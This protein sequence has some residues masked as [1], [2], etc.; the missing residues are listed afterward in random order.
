MRI[1]KGHYGVHMEPRTA[2]L[3]CHELRYEDFLSVKG[4]LDSM[5]DYQ[6]MAPEQLTDDNLLSI[7]WNKAPYRL[8]KEVG[9]IKDW[10]LQELF[11]QLLR[12][13]AR[14][15]ECDCCSKSKVTK[16]TPRNTA[17]VTEEDEVP[18]KKSTTPR[19]QNHCGSTEMQLKSVK[20]FKC[21]QK[22]HMAKDCPQT[23]DATRVITHE[24]ETI[25]EEESW[26][27]VR[28]LTTEEECKQNAVSNTGPTYKVNVV[29]E[30][31]HSR[32]LVDNGS[33]ISLVHTEMLPKLKE[34]N[35]WSM[36][37]CKS[38][39]CK[40]RSQ[41]QGA[42]G[43]E[44]GAKR[45]V[46]LSVTLEATGK[47]LHIPCYVVDSTR[48]LWQGAVKNCGLVLGTNAIVGFG[49]QLVHANATA[50]QPVNGNADLVDSATEKVARLVLCGVTR[51]GPRMTKRVKAKVVQTDEADVSDLEGGARVI[52]PNESVLVNVGCD[53]VEELWDVE[54]NVT[55]ELNNWG[56]EP[57]T[58]D[59]GQIGQIELVMVVGGDDTV[60][61]D[62]EQN[63]SFRVCQVEGLEER[64]EELRNRLQIAG[65]R[66][67]VDCRGINKDTIPDKYPI[68]RID[69]LIDM[70]G[71]HKPIVFTSLDLICGYHQVKMAWES[72][73]K[74]AFVC[75]LGQYQY[76]R[77]PFGLTN[78]P[79][80]FQ[81]LMSQLFS[82][83]EWE[84]VTVYLDD[85]LIASQN[86]KE[87]LEHIRKVL[88][89]LSEAGLRLKPSKCVFVASKIEYL[90]H[91][92][93]AQGVRP[94]SKKVEAVKCFPRPSTVKEVK[95]FLGLANFYCRHIPDT[96][97]ISRPLTLLTRKD[98][99]FDWTEE[100]EVAFCDIKERLVSAPVLHPP[101]QTQPFQLWTDAS[102]RGFG[103]VFE[104]TVGESRR[105]PI[106]YASRA[107]NDVECKYAT[108]EL[109]VAAFALEHF[110][111]YLLGN[112]VTVYSD[113]QALVSSFIPYLK[114]QTKGLL[115]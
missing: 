96:A 35:K 31:L 85:V 90:G 71:K 3:R 105:H 27:R 55:I 88:V 11:E 97:R 60:R 2:Y 77:M 73:H 49:I 114:S 22:G 70:V 21:H 79:A 13:E 65:L 100:C 80:T 15:E 112:K 23:T 14:V 63:T 92:L 41:P 101:D 19:R 4:L 59:K 91:T 108:T 51:I 58:L 37:E 8:Q 38:K 34:F 110:Q 81:R 10:S 54:S 102:E 82:G 76:R 87:H 115:V 7:L 95:S 89:Q 103:A 69:E 6:R 68:P 28:V 18:P 66:V 30:G 53:Y 17:A 113:H 74:T 99:H 67:C 12:A 94:N 57:Q 84:F 64:K 1:Y 36:E 43:S 20:C 39:T 47:S 5:K 46:L 52:S 56:A 48:P 40:M 72:M 16:Q 62:T 83:K 29:V 32:A 24:E 61:E 104:Q 33:Q 42:G 50:V 26:V 9:D 86:I 44:L 25:S 93:T 75:H 107:T 45:I 78:A 98:V 109:E 106:A 111:V